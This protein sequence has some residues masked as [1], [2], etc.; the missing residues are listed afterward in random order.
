MKI[1]E[2][3]EKIEYCLDKKRNWP[4]RVEWIRDGQIRNIE[5]QIVDVFKEEEQEKSMEQLRFNL[6]NEK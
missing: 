6:F 5:K 3:I 1:K 2:W 4:K